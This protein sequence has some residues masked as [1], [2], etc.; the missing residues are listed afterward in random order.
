[1]QREGVNSE[2]RAKIVS[3]F[4]ELGGSFGLDVSTIFTAVNYLDRFLSKRS[5]DCF[6]FRLASIGCLFLAVKVEERSP[7][8]AADFC[9]LTNGCFEVDDLRKMELELLSTL[10][11]RVHPATTLTYVGLLVCLYDGDRPVEERAEQL[12]TQALYDVELLKFPTSLQ[13]VSAV[14]CAMKD[15]DVPN[16]DVVTWLQLVNRCGFEYRNLPNAADFI[17]ECGYSF[18]SRAVDV[19]FEVEQANTPRAATPVN[20]NR[21][22]APSPND[23]TEIE[24]FI[25]AAHVHRSSKH[26][27]ARRHYRVSD[28]DDDDTELR[29]S[30]L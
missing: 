17:Q 15:L 8:L 4:H 18:Y 23:I 27:D 24:T 26:Y 13:A 28:D 10:R 22:H 25:H 5:C 2:W 12:V 16:D 9:G 21:P 7:I 3:W 20:P 29:R 6:N 1:M 19:D 11:W 30:L 14:I